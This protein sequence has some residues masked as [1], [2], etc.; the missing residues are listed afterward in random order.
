VNVEVHLKI[1]VPKD[2]IL[3][4]I[5]TADGTASIKKLDKSNFL[6]TE[7]SKR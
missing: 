3:D 5:E 6:N 7:F 4:K 2:M 1:Y